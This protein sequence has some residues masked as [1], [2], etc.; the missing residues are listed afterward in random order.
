MPE[1]VGLAH[2]ALSVRAA[3]SPKA[4]PRWP[5]DIKDLP[6]KDAGDHRMFQYEGA[7]PH[8][9]KPAAYHD[10]QIYAEEQRSVLRPAWHFACV[11]SQLRR[12]GAQV[13]CDIGGASV[14]VRRGAEGVFA[15]L[16]VCPHRHCELVPPGCTEQAALV[17][18]YHGWRFD[19]AGALAKL[20]DGPSWVG[21]KAHALGLRRI[22]VESLGALWFVCLEEAAPSLAEAMGPLQPELMRYFGAHRVHRVWVTE[23][24]VNWKVIAEN[25][26]E[27]YHVP[28]VHP[29][30]FQSYRDPRWHNH[31]IES[32]YTRYQDT[33]PWGADL[34]SMGAKAI[35]RLL[36][37]NAT[38]QRFT[39]THLF[40]T[41]LLY[42]NEL[43]SSLI[44]LTPLGPTRTRQTA[45]SLLPHSL[46]SSWLRPLQWAM[47]VAF[48]VLGGRVL[49]EDMRLWPAIQRGLTQS[50]HR[51]ALSC[52]E[53]RVYAFQ[54]Y[55]AARLPGARSVE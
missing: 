8:S 2:S 33:L 46:R 49:R 18:P 10:P 22:R 17:C 38:P 23:H 41:L 35:G 43:F 39:H 7:L 13:V 20:P 28:T 27:S 6:A 52:R 48:G 30:T 51:G 50:P 45:V 24:E 29:G 32:G 3:A 44:A 19:D 31:Q 15:F 36:Y 14:V 25:A 37:D 12:A 26:V 16:N 55:V 1:A 11:A 47:G 21:V 9:L 54:E 4:S 53:E 34:M 40:P 5:I 42:Y